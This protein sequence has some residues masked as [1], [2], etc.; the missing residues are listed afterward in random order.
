MSESEELEGLEEDAKLT[1][2][3]S[4]S[5]IEDEFYHRTQQID[6]RIKNEFSTLYTALTILCASAA[7]SFYILAKAEKRRDD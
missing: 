7:I 4:L 6:T 5:I 2:E 3:E 1:I